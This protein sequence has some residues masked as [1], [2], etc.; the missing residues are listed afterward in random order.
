MIK[1]IKHKGLKLLYEK[2]DKSKLANNMVD[3]IE[4]MLF[5]LDTAQDIDEIIRPSLK[6]HALKGNRQG[7]FSVTVRANWRIV[8]QFKDGD[9]FNVNFEDYH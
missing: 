3:R 5:A 7:E 9:I 8:F 4:E 6:L 2:G 1:S